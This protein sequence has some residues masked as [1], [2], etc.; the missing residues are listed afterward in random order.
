[1]ETRGDMDGWEHVGDR[2]NGETPVVSPGPSASSHRVMSAGTGC[3]AVQHDRRRSC[4]RSYALSH[5]CII[6]LMMLVSAAVPSRSASAE[7]ERDPI[8]VPTDVCR[9]YLFVPLT[10][11]SD[12]DEPDQQ[13]ERTLWFVYDTGSRRTYVD[14]N[15]LRR[16]SGRK[17]APG[18]RV[19]LVD[20]SAGPVQYRKL[21]AR[22]KDLADLSLG[23][24]REIDGILGFRA[25]G[26]HLVT[27]D[28]ES[29]QILL[30]KGRLPEA[31]GMTTVDADGP[32][33]RPWI[34]LD[35]GDHSRQM[36]ID[37]GAAGMSLVVRELER[38]DTVGE[39]RLMNVSVQL[40]GTEHVSAARFAG[41]VMLGSATLERPILRSTAGTEVIGGEI[42]QHFLWTFDPLTKR[43]KVQRNHPGTPIRFDSVRGNGAML[44]PEGDYLRVM[45]VSEGGPAATA[46]LRAGDL[47]THVDGMPVRTRGCEGFDEQVEL[48]VLRDGAPRSVSFRQ[49]ILVE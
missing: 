9:G 28:Y 45:S 16:I 18:R 5:A 33:D 10:F 36:L 37:S 34:R 39:A 14:P 19:T 38:F 2:K 11:Q 35:F 3:E 42:M 13:A 26:D 25:F 20:L 43:V 8:V 7:T 17:I 47:V 31:D 32:D 23:L 48:T 22:V 4:G 21:S 44:A 24:G 1:M 29:G 27:L 40:A 15:S 6:V 30:S 49:H 12:R 46:G 41:D